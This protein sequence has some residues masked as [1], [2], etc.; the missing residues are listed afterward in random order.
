MYNFLTSRL[1]YPSHNPM[2][3]M[4]F[5]LQMMGLENLKVDSE[6]SFYKLIQ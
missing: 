5:V 6:C 2:V 3:L 1:I 4:V